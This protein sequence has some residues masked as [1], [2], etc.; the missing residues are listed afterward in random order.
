MTHVVCNSNLYPGIRISYDL[1]KTIYEGSIV[2]VYCERGYTLL[3][4]QRMKRH[5]NGSYDVVTP[6]CQSS[7]RC[8][9]P[10][11]ENGYTG[12][13]GFVPEGETVYMACNYGLPN[14][15]QSAKCLS[16]GF[17]YTLGPKFVNFV[18]TIA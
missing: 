12:A 1:R 6:M 5:D 15:F 8:P 7:V 10:D 9:V 16:T 3:G 13:Q 2:S 4:S 11:I 18:L 17:D 14:G